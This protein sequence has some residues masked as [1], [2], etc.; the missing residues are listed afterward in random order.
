MSGES[1]PPLSW[2][3]NHKADLS[4]LWPNSQTICFSRL[5]YCMIS[6]SLLGLWMAWMKTFLIEYVCLCWVTIIWNEQGLDGSQTTSTNTWQVYFIFFIFF[7]RLFY[8]MIIFS[9]LGLWM[10]WRKIF[11]AEYTLLVLGNWN[12]QVL[13]CSLIQLFGN[14]PLFIAFNQTLL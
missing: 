5:F 14:E 13:L 1:R 9:L 8:R 12:K 3:E 10:T 4:I 11:L 2:S 7:S 6:F